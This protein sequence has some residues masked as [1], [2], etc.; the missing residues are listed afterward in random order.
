MD[1]SKTMDEGSKVSNEGKASNE[2]K[3]SHE[4]ELSVSEV[5][6]SAA[7]TAAV[8]S[9]PP[10]TSSRIH[11]GKSSRYTKQR[12]GLC[13][14]MDSHEPH[15]HYS[16]PVDVWIKSIVLKGAIQIVTRNKNKNMEDD[17]L[18]SSKLVCENFDAL[19]KKPW[20]NFVPCDVKGGVLGRIGDM[21]VLLVGKKRKRMDAYKWRKFV[22]V[23]ISE[24]WNQ[25][26]GKKDKKDGTKEGMKVEFLRNEIRK[27]E[28]L[29]RLMKMNGMEQS[30][31]TCFGVMEFIVLVVRLLN[32]VVIRIVD[33]EEKD[34]DGFSILS[35]LMNGCDAFE[36]SN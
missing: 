11:G 35:L 28:D 21:Y 2:S 12:D 29:F 18:E 15:V 8:T 19:P 17:F 20:Y 9:T 5:A 33:D 36:K 32:D 22:T 26:N 34:E 31:G 10:A 16:N 14:C 7:A 23:V 30:T 3:V 6:I 4:V 25:L 27:A 13:R 1:E 24:I